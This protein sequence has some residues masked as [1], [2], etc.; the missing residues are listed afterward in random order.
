MNYAEKAPEHIQCL[1][2][3]KQA[4]AAGVEPAT[5]AFGERCSAN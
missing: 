1:G 5:F 4:G 3:F 2:A